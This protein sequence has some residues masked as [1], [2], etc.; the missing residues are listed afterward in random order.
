MAREM[1]LGFLYFPQVERVE[2]FD[3][4]WV[5]D[6]WTKERAAA[7]LKIMRAMGSSCM[8]IHLTPPVPGAT[9]YDRLNDRRVT[10]I[11]GK[12]YLEMLDHV[13]KTARDVGLLVHF[14]IASSFSEVS[15]E[16]LD[17]WIPRYRGLVESYQFANE[18]WSLF[19]TDMQEGSSASFQRFEELLERARRLDP[20]AK[21]TA[22]IFA[23]QV[24]HIRNRFPRLFDGLDVL[25]THPYY[26]ADHR[27]WTE[28]YLQQLVA[29]H[30]VG[31]KPLPD[32]PWLPD[33]ILLQ[34][35]WGIAD[36]GKPVWV[37]ELVA[38]GDGVWSCLVPDEVQADGWRRAVDGLATCPLVTRIY[39][40]WFTDKMHSMESGITHQLGAVR[41]DGSPKLLTKAFQETAEAYAPADSLVRLLCIE[42]PAVTAPEGVAGITLTCKIS[43]RG[44]APISGRARVELPAGITTATEPFDFALAPG[45]TLSRDLRLSIGELSE[46]ANHVF[47]RVEASGQTHYGWGVV[48]RPRPL[49]LGRE[50]RG[51]PGIR[52]LPDTDAVQAF[53]T[54][55]GDECAIVVGP[56]ALHWDTELGYRLKIVLESMRG[57]PVPLKTWFMISEVWDRPLVI[58]GRPEI[59]F[60]AQL[61]EMG[62]PAAGRAESLAPGEGFLQVIDRPLGVQIGPPEVTI[63]EK[64]VGFHACPAGLYV[65]GGDAEG[66]KKAAYE[67]IRRLWNPKDGTPGPK[68]AW[69]IG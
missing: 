51:L 37:T 9:A 8:R 55:Y 24:E 18:N 28:P 42:V 20:Q 39:H 23:P 25:S 21:Y 66:T 52:H 47:L 49:V 16:S 6:R 35:F 17:G 10:P 31:A 29:S 15:E 67:L 41:Y 34:K 60:I 48:N 11:T 59:N 32:F 40:A 62:L 5:L 12:R 63:R 54:R 13:V 19:E 56:G 44:A 2:S 1:L 26:Y 57:H 50:K 43:N 27:G 53:L 64:L 22:D 33:Q 4:W 45:H 7:D 65:A 58:L 30:T 3:P 61:V 68:A 14:D 36:F 69:L 38:S 46:T